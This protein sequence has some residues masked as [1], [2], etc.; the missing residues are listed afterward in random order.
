MHINGA[1]K[2][3][4]VIFL[5]LLQIKFFGYKTQIKRPEI[6]I[7]KLQSPWCVY[8]GIEWDGKVFKTGQLVI[9]LFTFIILRLNLKFRLR[10]AISLSFRPFSKPW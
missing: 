3:H 2:N 9:F 4:D 10:V 8:Q 7:K 1:F 5:F 6:P